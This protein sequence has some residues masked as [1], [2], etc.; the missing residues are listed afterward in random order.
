[1]EKVV[2]EKGEWEWE[3]EGKEKLLLVEGDWM[4]NF[5]DLSVSLSSP[6]PFVSPEILPF[7]PFDLV[8]SNPPYLSRDDFE[9]GKWGNELI[10]MC[11]FIFCS[12]SFGVEPTIS[13]L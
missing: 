10:Y 3:G 5:Y 1:M 8:V 9:K 4:S 2:V 6:S 11:S 13:F 12:F 7:V